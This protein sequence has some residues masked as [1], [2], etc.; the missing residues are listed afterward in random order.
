MGRCVTQVVCVLALA[1]GAVSVGYAQRG[2]PQW[3]VLGERGVTD[4]ADHDV[5]PVTA[6]RGTFDAIRLA[7]R[8]HAVDFQRVVIHFANGDDQNVE[9]RATI[10]AGGQSRVIDVDGANRVI[11][12]IEFWYDAKTRGRGG[13]ALV[14][15]LGRH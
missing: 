13:R 5:I 11:T 2:N 7:V 9:L 10:P 12:S 3:A 8:N 1:A 14:R 4:G 6:A 15:A